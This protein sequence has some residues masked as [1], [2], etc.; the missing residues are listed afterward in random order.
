M[1]VKRNGWWFPTS[2]FPEVKLT[3][4]SDAEKLRDFL[5]EIGQH[6][7]AEKVQTHIQDQIEF[8]YLRKDA[9]E[10]GDVHEIVSRR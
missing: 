7:E 5:K 2:V 10:E 8:K 9:Y 4:M 3:S 6:D 1:K